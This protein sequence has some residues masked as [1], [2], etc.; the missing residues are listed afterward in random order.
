M[1]WYSQ[2]AFAIRLE[3]GIAALDH[4]AGNVDAI[5][6][7]DVMSFS[8]SVSLAVENG[9]RVYP[10]P[11]KDQTVV[12]YAQSVGAVA[13][14]SDRRFGGEGYSLSPRTLLSV[15]PGERLVL[16]SPNGSATCFRAREWGVP[17]LTGCLRNL[18]ATAEACRPFKRLLIVPCGERWPDGSLRPCIEDYVVAGGIIAALER[19]SLSPEAQTAVAAWHAH[20]L[21]DFTALFHCSSATELIQ[22]G[23]PEDVTLCLTKDAARRPCFLSGEYFALRAEA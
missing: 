19:N 6:I 2:D 4:L 17:V 14:N 1:H 9:A 11:W 10:Y 12:H 7:V 8:T 22:R 18:T 5:V 21:Q 13:A 16:P 23:F 3:W 15:R 20:Q